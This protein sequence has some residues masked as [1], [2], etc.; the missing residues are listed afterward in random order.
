MARLRSWH[1]GLVALLALAVAVLAQAP[2]AGRDARIPP[3]AAGA[4]S[5]MDEP[6]RLA[7]LARQSYQQ[8]Q[9]YTCLLIKR[10]RLRGQ[11]EPDHLIRMRVRTQ[12]FSVYLRWQG[13]RQF[14]GQETC[15]VAGQ[16]N[17]MMR[18]HGVGLAGLAGWVSLDPRDPRVLEHSRHTITEA[19][20]GNLI[21]RYGRRWEEERRLNQTQVRL[22][23][24]TY[25]NR[26][27]RRVETIHPPGGPYAFYR[28]LV[29]FDSA[30]HLPIRV[31]N[32]DWPRPRGNPDGDL[33]EMYSY[34]DL[35]LNVR[36][37]EEAFNY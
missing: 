11:L 27:C 16:N 8:V 12:P 30:T 28:S 21:E 17:G 9:T 3:P 25:D 36:L 18:V 10:E 6:L 7:H 37:G 24:F 13:P 1:L 34:A 29:Y 4:P 31:E 14:A 15:Y 19:G 32:Y 2:P 33:A 20:I 5:A 26:L 22:G 23:N 35:R